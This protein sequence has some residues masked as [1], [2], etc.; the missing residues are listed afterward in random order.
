MKHLRR[1]DEELSPG[2]Y[3]RAAEE[4]AKIHGDVEA[5]KA[6]RDWA[7]KSESGGKG[8]DIVYTCV[9]EGRPLYTGIE[10]T[11]N[12]VKPTVAGVFFGSVLEYPKNRIGENTA[13]SIL[14]DWKSN[15]RSLSVSMV[16]NFEKTEVVDRSW[17]YEVTII[18]SKIGE[19]N[20][21]VQ[22]FKIEKEQE[23]SALIALGQAIKA[24]Y[25]KIIGSPL[26]SDAVRW[27]I[28]KGPTLG[29]V[30][31]GEMMNKISGVGWHNKFKDYTSTLSTFV[32]EVRLSRSTYGMNDQYACHACGGAVTMDC[33][34]CDGE[35]SVWSDDADDNVT[36]TTCNGTGTITCEEC[37]GEDMVAK[38]SPFKFF[39]DTFYPEVTM[40]PIPGNLT[41]NRDE[42]YSQYPWIGMFM[43]RDDARRFLSDNWERLIN[44]DTRSK[45][46]KNGGVGS[47]YE[48]ITDLVKEA[49]DVNDNKAMDYMQEAIVAVENISVA[50]MVQD[51]DA[52][53]AVESANRNFR[54][55]STYRPKNK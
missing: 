49:V 43:A 19:A 22:T 26:R 15:G 32:I 4:K 6:L 47:F 31:G 2:V 30:K 8:Y 7:K 25:P 14:S 35:G 34:D 13:D 10:Y 55:I 1:F 27:K 51:K 20:D 24:A 21:Q 37:D 23:H 28:V 16:V 44:E 45:F 17:T 54:N 12:M 52:K 33:Y 18:G 5:A 42:T 41:Y 53:L 3:N 50:A 9:R 36:C 29:V 48:A 11:A 38:V 40:R 39:E 46:G